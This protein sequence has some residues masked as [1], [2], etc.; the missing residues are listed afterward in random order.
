[1]SRLQSA[2]AKIDDI[3]G[4]TAGHTA[5]SQHVHE[6]RSH[7][8]YMEGFHH[9]Y[10][11]GNP[12]FRKYK[13]KEKYGSNDQYRKGYD[14]GKVKSKEVWDRGSVYEAL[15]PTKGA[16][17]TKGGKFAS[18][19]K[20][21]GAQ[22]VP[23]VSPKVRSTVESLGGK[24]KAWTSGGGLAFVFEDVDKAEKAFDILRESGH[25]VV[26]HDVPGVLYFQGMLG[27]SVTEGNAVIARQ[28][29]FASTMYLAATINALT[30][31]G[32]PDHGHQ[33]P[34]DKVF[35]DEDEAEVA[36]V[37]LAQA[38]QTE[39]AVICNADGEYLAIPSTEAFEH[40]S[41]DPEVSI[42]A[43]FDPKGQQVSD[44]DDDTP[45]HESVVNE[46]T[47]RHSALSRLGNAMARK[48]LAGG[49]RKRFRSA[50]RSARN[51]LRRGFIYQAK[52]K[53]RSSLHRPN[54]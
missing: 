27:E 19:K 15:D 2:L 34:Y 42:H 26:K 45:M 44:A 17:R 52:A 47:E 54:G 20:S 16:F 36:A 29:A 51:R 38:N 40:A 13:N 33:D 30:A 10:A 49:F 3:I 22:W 9:G 8:D 48:K 46:L 7:P 53:A 32:T 1:M 11:G 24:V 43:L 39:W 21:H 50:R 5:E 28:A 25:R 31:R 4:E 12:Q 37:G 23:H 6:G 14:D 18:L 41:I 35:A